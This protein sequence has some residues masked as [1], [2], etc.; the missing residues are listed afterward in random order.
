MKIK[1]LYIT[2]FLGGGGLKCIALVKEGNTQANKVL[3]PLHPWAHI[4]PPSFHLVGRGEEVLSFPTFARYSY[5]AWRA[6]SQH[7]LLPAPIPCVPPKRHLQQED[8]CVC[9]IYNIY[10]YYIIFYIYVWLSSSN[11]YIYKYTNIHKSSNS[12]I[13]TYWI[14][15]RPSYIKCDISVNDAFWKLFRGYHEGN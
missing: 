5:K 13:F 8:M 14:S 7:L 2:L 11:T 1:P 9:I 15:S 10:V 12:H 6:C 4:W 3:G